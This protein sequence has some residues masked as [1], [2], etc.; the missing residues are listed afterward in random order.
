MPH[1]DMQRMTSMPRGLLVTAVSALCYAATRHTCNRRDISQL[2][3]SHACRSSGFTQAWWPVHQEARVFRLR[4]HHQGG[5]TAHTLPCC[6]SN[7]SC[8]SAT[9]GTLVQQLQLLCTL[10]V[11]QTWK[12]V[13]GVWSQQETLQGHTDW[14]R[15]VAWAP[16]LGL[17]KSTIASAGQDGQVRVGSA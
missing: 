4:Q 14:V 1:F 11:L 3:T 8:G 6:Q 17:P 15:D 10:S 12:C 16:N 5:L 7:L 9:S 2:G 13:D